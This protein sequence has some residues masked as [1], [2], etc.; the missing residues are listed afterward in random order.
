MFKSYR[1]GF[2]WG[3]LL[4]FLWL[5][6]IYRRAQQF[7]GDPAL[8]RYYAWIRNLSPENDAT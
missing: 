3:L 4:G 7:P 1:R 8:N 5:F 6:W 2:G